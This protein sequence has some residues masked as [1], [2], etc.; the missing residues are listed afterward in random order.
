MAAIK[1]Y[2]NAKGEPHRTV[3]V[4]NRGEVCRVRS[5]E[6]RVDSAAETHLREQ[7]GCVLSPLISFQCSPLP[8]W[9]LGTVL[10]VFTDSENHQKG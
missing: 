8:A 9:I 6:R 3:S 4:N 10:E 1:A 7:L 5:G 2:L